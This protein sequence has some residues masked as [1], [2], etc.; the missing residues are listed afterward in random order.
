VGRRK[1]SSLTGIGIALLIVG[2][3]M[4][5]LRLLAVI[6]HLAFSLAVPI[7][8]IGLALLLIGHF[9]RR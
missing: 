4:L 5:S 6:V 3:I 7:L 8:L 2:A 1:T 9:S